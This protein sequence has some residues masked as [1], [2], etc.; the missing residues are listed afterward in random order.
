[1]QS[2]LEHDSSSPEPGA[3]RPG[4][5]KL[6]A[7]FFKAERPCPLSP[8]NG[9]SRR[10]FVSGRLPYP[11]VASRQRKSTTFPLSGFQCY[12]FPI[13]GCFGRSNR[14]CCTAIRALASVPRPASFPLSCGRPL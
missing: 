1:M 14:G 10:A 3:A 8:G 6:I 7:S 4:R 11:K 5:L 9:A 12:I 13:P 2:S